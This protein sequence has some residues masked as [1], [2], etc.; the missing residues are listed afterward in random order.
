MQISAPATKYRHR[1]RHPLSAPIS[2]PAIR[3][4]TI[5]TMVGSAGADLSKAALISDDKFFVAS[6]KDTPLA[7]ILFANLHEAIVMIGR[8]VCNTLIYLLKARLFYLCST[9]LMLIAAPSVEHTYASIKFK[10]DFCFKPAY[11]KKNST[12]LCL[13]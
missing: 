13:A 8:D 1:H 3:G 7:V 5:T 6:G 2:A 9:L 12:L 10:R 11:E 4:M